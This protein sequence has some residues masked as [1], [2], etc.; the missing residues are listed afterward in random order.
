MQ[1]HGKTSGRS[2]AVCA[3]GTALLLAALSAAGCQSGSPTATPSSPSRSS[4]AVT[5]SVDPST[6]AAIDASVAAYQGYFAAYAV[7]AAVPDPDDPNLARYAGGAL[8]SLSQHN[9]RTLKDHGAVELGHP[10][11]TVTSSRAD[12]SASPPTVTVQACV[13]Y[14]DY[15]LVFKVNQSPVP[16]GSLARSRYATTATVNLFTD[17][18]WLVVGDT[19]HRDTPC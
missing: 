16:S 8:L 9:L 11:T 10:K 4:T 13:D 5:P 17:G 2:V 12:L 15:R 18:Q 7:A 6:A 1:R 3:L 19:P 14:S